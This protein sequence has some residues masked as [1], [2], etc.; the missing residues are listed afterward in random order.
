MPLLLKVIQ[1]VKLDCEASVSENSD[2]ENS[3]LIEIKSSSQLES[4]L[5]HILQG[6]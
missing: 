4:R 6:D 5:I 2:H 1:V 3:N